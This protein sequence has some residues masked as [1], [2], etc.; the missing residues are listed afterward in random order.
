MSSNSFDRSDATT[1]YTSLESIA[2]ITDISKLETPTSTPS[3]IPWT[4]DP[5][6]WLPYFA[7]IPSIIAGFLS[8]SSIYSREIEFIG[9]RGHG[10]D[11]TRGWCIYADIWLSINLFLFGLLHL[12]DGANVY[13]LFP[14][15]SSL[16]R[17]HPKTEG[18][19]TFS[20]ILYFIIFA[21][22]LCSLIVWHYSQQELQDEW[23]LHGFDE[24]QQLRLLNWGIYF[25]YVLYLICLLIASSMSLYMRGNV[26]KHGWNDQLDTYRTVLKLCNVL[27]AR[28]QLLKL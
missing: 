17:Q 12:L 19:F 18:C 25:F 13:F 7:F 4:L 21:F 24:T 14:Y 26:I 1:Q 22:Q 3:I 20:T 23:V 16:T 8:S 9:K 6:C 2:D 5:R 27:T 10:T 11:L 15:R 28:E